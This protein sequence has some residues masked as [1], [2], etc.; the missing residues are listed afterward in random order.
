MSVSGLVCNRTFVLCQ[1]R[2]W[3]PTRA[4]AKCREHPEKHST[5]YRELSTRHLLQDRRAVVTDD[6][7]ANYVARFA[8]PVHVLQMEEGGRSTLRGY[9]GAHFPPRFDF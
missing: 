3:T 1:V 6:R 7:P 4:H 8:G 2:I 5:C 9:R